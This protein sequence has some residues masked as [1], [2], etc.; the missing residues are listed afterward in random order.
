MTGVRRIGAAAAALLLLAAC[1][2]EQPQQ[3]P[4]RV[5]VTTDTEGNTV[6][7]TVTETVTPDEV[8]ATL[9]PTLPTGSDPQAAT[10][11]VLSLPALPTA[12]P[13]PGAPPDP[14]ATTDPTTTSAPVTSAPPGP[15]ARTGAVELMLPQDWEVIDLGALSAPPGPSDLTPAH[16][17]CLVPGYPIPSIDGCAGVTVVLGTD[18]LPGAGGEPYQAGQPGGWRLPEEPLACPFHDAPEEDEVDA[19]AEGDP[20]AQVEEEQDANVVVDL[21]DGT[22]LT[23]VES[24]IGDHL[25]RYETWRVRCSETNEV[26]TPQLW[27]VRDLGVIVTD[28]FGSPDTHLLLESL[29][30]VEAP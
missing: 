12:T 26:F 6:T 30:A 25:I 1:S 24:R 19:E 27:Q 16:H 3:A 22:P 28:Y 23:S 10:P 21:A 8:E 2:D 9:D 29:T 15:A 4:P 18:W 13:P 20:D 11:I 5:E 7:V 14:T 17:W